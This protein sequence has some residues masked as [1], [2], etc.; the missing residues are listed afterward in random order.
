MGS[1]GTCKDNGATGYVG[2]QA[3][4]PESQGRVASKGQGKVATV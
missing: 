3:T 1:D 2:T 4:E